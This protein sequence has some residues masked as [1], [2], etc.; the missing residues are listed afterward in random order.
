[1]SI[2]TINN[3]LTS[4]PHDPA[5]MWRL[6]SLLTI[7]GKDF[8]S[9]FLS[10]YDTVLRADIHSLWLRWFV[11]GLCN[12]LRYV[13]DQ[14]KTLVDV[15]ADAF[16]RVDL[17]YPG[18]TVEQRNTLAQ[19]LA[20]QVMAE[21]MRQ[22]IIKRIG[23]SAGDKQDLVDAAVNTPRCYIC[24]YAF[25]QIAID[26][27]LHKRKGIELPLPAFV[28]VLQPRGLVERDVGIEVEHI[29][30]V[31]G[32]G[33]GKNNLALACGWCNKSKGALMSMY[34][35]AARAA[36]A[37]YFMGTQQWYELPN[38]FWTIR[39]L[40][41]VGKCEHREGCQATV[42]DSELFI[43][44]VDHHGSPNPCNLRVFCSQHDPYAATRFY[45]RD[46]V[47]KI[48]EERVR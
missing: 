24:G 36:R 14:T 30:P 41:V 32:G 35:T 6:E 44:P 37:S 11:E 22:R 4:T 34:D 15:T 20:K 7:S 13:E 39:I 33:Q 19:H 46:A 40:A 48:W 38:P 45:G 25:S 1:V 21:V 26:K 12:P 27:F 5:G 10:R 23:T 28:D 29:V 42:K 2:Q 16:A 17:L 9:D 31:A 47:Q 3:Y 8:P 18:D 43:A